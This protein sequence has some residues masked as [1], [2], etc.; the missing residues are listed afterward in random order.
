VIEYG[1]NARVNVAPRPSILV[2]T[3]A[4]LAGSLMVLVS[5]GLPAVMVIACPLVATDASPLISTRTG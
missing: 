5:S 2:V 4:I 3:G 1:G